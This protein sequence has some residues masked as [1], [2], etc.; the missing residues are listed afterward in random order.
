MTLDPGNYTAQVSGVPVNADSQADGETGVGL[1]EVFEVG[2]TGTTRLSNISTRGVVDTE[3]DVM[4]AGLIIGGSTPKTV[5][6]RARGPALAD[7]G[8]AG[9]LA[10]PFLQLFSGQTEIAKNDNWQT[11]DPLCA[12]PATSC[13]GATEIT[14]TGLDPC[15]PVPL[16]GQPPTPTGCSMESA[17]LVTLPP[18]N[19]TAQVSGV[20]GGTGV[21]LV[22]VF[23]VN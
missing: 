11:T 5:L 15:Q 17:V 7:F 10:N 16:P 21:G 12:A 18:G 14:A 20:S 1:V 19:Y 4:I 8:V 2:T 9:V 13:G 3:D 23:E 6:V 22:E